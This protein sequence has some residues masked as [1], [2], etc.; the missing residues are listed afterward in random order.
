MMTMVSQ[1]TDIQQKS[2]SIFVTKVTFGEREKWRLQKKPGGS[3]QA[4][5]FEAVSK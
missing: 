1:K 3:K 2:D 5:Q 4:G